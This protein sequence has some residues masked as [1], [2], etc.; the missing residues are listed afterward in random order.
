MKIVFGVWCHVVWWTTHVSEERATSIFLVE[1]YL[2]DGGN[3]SSTTSTIY[4][5]TRGLVAEGVI[6]IAA[7]NNNETTSKVN[8]KLSLCLIN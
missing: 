8:A 6:F 2:E 5:T 7:S 3:L 4:Q 1:D